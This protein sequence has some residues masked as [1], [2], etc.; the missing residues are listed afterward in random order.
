MRDAPLI[1]GEYR[2]SR[3]RRLASRR[4]P[5]RS[6]RRRALA[7]AGVLAVAGALA[8]A[9]RWLLTAPVFTVARIEAGPYRF[10]DRE[11]VQAALGACLQRNIWTLSQRDVAATCAP[12]PWV[13]EVRL[14]RRI[15]D[16]VVVD[17]IEWQPLLAVSGGATLADDRFLVG[18]G[19][20]LPLPDHLPPPVLPLLVG[21]T[22]LTAPD[23]TSRLPTDEIEPVLAVIEALAE[24]GLESACPV[25]F[26]RLTAEGFVLI[27]QG[28][29]GSLLLGR[30]DFRLRLAR[31]LLARPRIPE[32]SVVDLRF[33]DRITFVPA[34]AAS[35]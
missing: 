24:T 19:R 20:V 22:L 5:H 13:R 34:A 17:L 6:W 31:Y 29:A 26:V 32:G 14:A 7:V 1:I 4:R 2:G 9:G 25:D 23:G 10:S 35:T 30:E 3:G 15:P 11:A 28:R 33:E 21:A 27:L 12:L 18:D 8:G 16:T